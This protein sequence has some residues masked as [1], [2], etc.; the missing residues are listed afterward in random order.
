MCG[1]S[2]AARPLSLPCARPW[3]GGHGVAPGQGETCG[4]LGG[5]ARGPQSA[6][7]APAEQYF[8]A[9]GGQQPAP[10]RR[11]RSAGTS[12]QQGRAEPPGRPAPG[13]A[14]PVALPEAA[15]RGRS[16]RDVPCETSTGSAAATGFS[17]GKDSAGSRRRL[18]PGTAGQRVRWENQIQK[19]QQLS[20]G[21]R[22]QSKL[23]A[24]SDSSGQIG[25]SSPREGAVSGGGRLA[26]GQRGVQPPAA[27]R[28]LVRGW[29][30]AK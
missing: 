11:G 15:R 30:A 13:Q 10:V 14:A 28:S 24:G 9:G 3:R 21:G 20:H 25:A 8:E 6:F 19:G 22:Q 29:R 4:I 5:G 23:R 12:P 7:Q 26:A 17:L 27:A 18:S 16:N 1:A 2:P